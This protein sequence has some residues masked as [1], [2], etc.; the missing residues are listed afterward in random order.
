MAS[1]KVVIP[2]TAMASEPSTAVMPRGI[3]LEAKQKIIPARINRDNTLC[4]K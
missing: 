3:T 1:L 2:T 4:D